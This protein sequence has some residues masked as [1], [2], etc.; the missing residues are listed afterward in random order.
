MAAKELAPDI[1]LF[2]NSV[3]LENGKQHVN[4]IN[5]KIL[6][7]RKLPTASGQ[8]SNSNSTTLHPLSSKINGKVSHS[9]GQDHVSEFV[10]G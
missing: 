2:N 4:S 10:S 1:I 3:N 5:S 8:E 9:I 6:K 7:L